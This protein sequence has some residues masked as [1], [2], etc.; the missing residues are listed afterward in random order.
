MCLA[1]SRVSVT[2]NAEFII[3]FLATFCHFLRPVCVRVCVCVNDDALVAKLDT[4][5]TIERK[6]LR[7]LVDSIPR[8]DLAMTSALNVQF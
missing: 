2:L 8:T 7:Q 3:Y 4:L 5:R 6:K 1:R